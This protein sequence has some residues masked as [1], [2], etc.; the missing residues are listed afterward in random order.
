[1]VGC[2]FY[3]LFN[4]F[5][6]KI[7]KTTK[8]VTKKKNEK[9]IT[10]FS[11]CI[12]LLLG[13]SACRKYHDCGTDMGNAPTSSWTKVASLPPN[14]SFT[15]L[16][17]SGNTIY[18]ASAAGV[19]YSSTDMGST[20][21]ASATVK[22]GTSISALAIF[23]NTLYV[24][25]DFDGIFASSNNGQSWV[26]Q[27]AVT[28]ITSFTVLDNNLYASSSEGLSPSGGMMMLNQQAG[29]WPAFNGNGLPGNY[30][31]AVY[32]TIVINQSLVSIRGVNG[33]LYAYS[34]TGGLWRSTTYFNPHRTATMRD[35]VYSQGSMLAT[36]GTMLFGSAD[37]GVTWA[38]DT[39]GLQ[40]EPGIINEPHIRM[41]YMANN[42]FYVVSN[43]LTGGGINVQQRDITA[44]IGSSWATNSDV[45]PSSGFAYAIRSLNSVLFL[46]TDNGLYF[47]HI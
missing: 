46:A 24:G 27:S 21:L 37:A 20:W 10:L 45:L 35:V 34:A 41:L 44:P 33:F 29:T 3:V 42:K 11:V 26:N 38:A 13:L 18:A 12:A 39:A 14:Q 19:V 15:L 28:Q 22:Q 31:F 32:K 23:N 40:K 17:T 30:D 36:P 1:M 7:V 2:A 16:E 4:L 25:T 6:Q 9:I 5:N 47:K 8:P 43:I